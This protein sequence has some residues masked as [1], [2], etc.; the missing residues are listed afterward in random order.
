MAEPDDER[1][2]FLTPSCYHALISALLLPL[3][4][5]ARVHPIENATNMGNCV[6]HGGINLPSI[7]LTSRERCKAGH[8]SKARPESLT[9]LQFVNLTHALW[10]RNR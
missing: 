6:A 10:S 4:A 1:A 2:A 8:C 3:W 5:T 9:S 7:L